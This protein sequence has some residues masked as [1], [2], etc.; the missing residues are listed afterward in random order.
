MFKS[1]CIKLLLFCLIGARPVSKQ[2]SQTY[3]PRSLLFVNKNL[4]NATCALSMS[5]ASSSSSIYFTSLH[6]ALS[7]IR[8]FLHLLFCP[9]ASKQTNNNFHHIIKIIKIAWDLI[10][11]VRPLFGWK[12]LRQTLRMNCY[13]ILFCLFVRIV[14]YWLV[15]HK[16]YL[17]N[18]VEM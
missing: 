5:F 1:N 8:F 16:H 2:L 18:F 10:D 3:Q 6:L 12:A 7:T 17:K 9:F 15:G 11:W 14:N 4:M 13:E